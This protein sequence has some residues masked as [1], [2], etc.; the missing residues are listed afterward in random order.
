MYFLTRA[1]ASRPFDVLNEIS[2]WTNVLLSINLIMGTTAFSMTKVALVVS[3]LFLGI[4]GDILF[5]SDASFHEF[6]S[7][8]PHG[9]L[10]PLAENY[11]V[12]ISVGEIESC[13]ITSESFK[14]GRWLKVLNYSTGVQRRNLP[15]DP[16]RL[17]GCAKRH[18]RA[19]PA[20]LPLAA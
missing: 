12:N 4:T 3:R 1:A 19:S 14:F 18:H 9:Q 15:T 16:G 5:S 7:Q 13:V 17:A 2:T 8:L 11:H 20:R 10:L 6:I